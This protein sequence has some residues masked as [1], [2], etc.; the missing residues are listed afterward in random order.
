[1]LPKVALIPVVTEI[2]VIYYGFINWKKRNLK[3]YEF[4]Y[5]KDSGT[6]TL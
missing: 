4:L 3:P 5:H 2:A 1:M 6:I